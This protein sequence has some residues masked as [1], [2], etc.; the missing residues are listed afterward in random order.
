MGTQLPSPQK[1]QS[2][3]FFGPCLLYPNGSMDQDA[4][5]YGGRPR[6]K[7][8]CI[9][10]GPS[11]PP[12]ERVRA[13]QFS[14]HV[15]CGQMA[16]SIKMPRGMEVGLHPRHIVLDGNPA[17]LSKKGA[18]PPPPNFWPCLLWPNGWMDQVATWYNG[19]PRPDNT[20]LDADPAPP[21]RDSA[22]KYRPMSVVANGWMVK[23]PLGMKVGLGSGR[24]V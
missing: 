18:Q 6:P 20:A 16:A 24:I 13:P 19:R 15:Y 11:S 10:R 1:R 7:R 14:A 21:R 8:H 23:M 22:P 9:R 2:P 5:W 12:Q 4:T 17:T 3:H